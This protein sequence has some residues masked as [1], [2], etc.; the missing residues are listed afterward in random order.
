MSN[1]NVSVNMSGLLA[2]LLTV[3]FVA[4]KLTGIITW[5][6]FW[7]FSPILIEFVFVIFLLIFVLMC[8]IFFNSK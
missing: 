7:V 4:L 5:S 3:L 8:F 1:S 6:W 2:T